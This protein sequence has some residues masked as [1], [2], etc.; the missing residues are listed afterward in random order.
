[1]LVSGTPPDIREADGN[2]IV[3]QT[4]TLAMI[5]TFDGTFAVEVRFVIHPSGE[6]ND[7]GFATF[8]GTVDGQYGTLQ[9][10][11]RGTPGPIDGFTIVSGSD[12]LANLRGHGTVIFTGPGS[13]T[14]SG[15]VHFDP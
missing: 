3:S 10:R 1:V 7:H 8:T 14:Y 12:G 5:G 15:Q 13:G 4:L 11:T 2:L 6:V 9:L